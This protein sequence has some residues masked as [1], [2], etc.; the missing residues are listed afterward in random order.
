MY[1]WVIKQR[2]KL[3]VKECY[4]VGGNTKDV[5][6]MKFNQLC[7]GQLLSSGQ[8]AVHSLLRVTATVV[9]IS[10]VNIHSYIFLTPSRVWVSLW[11]ALG[12]CCQK[13]VL[14]S[15]TASSPYPQIHE[16]QVSPQLLGSQSPQPRMWTIAFS[17]DA[18]CSAG[19][20]AVVSKET[21]EKKMTPVKPRLQWKPR[22]HQ[23]CNLSLGLKNR[24]PLCG[25]FPFFHLPPVTTVSKS[26]TPWAAFV[27][28][29]SLW[30][31]EVLLSPFYR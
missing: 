7:R 20:Q 29:T 27:L 6:S 18:K 23:R 16:Q 4:V 9:W 28:T 25:T 21:F 13:D 30:S 12:G 8:T 24:K 17:K 10:Q 1:S 19:M 3:N 26:P 5:V 11:H 15:V 14:H 22:S 2:L 31:R